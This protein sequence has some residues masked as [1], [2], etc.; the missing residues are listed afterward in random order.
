MMCLSTCVAACYRPVYLSSDN[1][2]CWQ[3]ITTNIH[4]QHVNDCWEEERHRKHISTIMKV[5][6]FD[7]PP[8]VHVAWV[9]YRCACKKRCFIIKYHS[10]KLMNSTILLLSKFC[11]TFRGHQELLLL[12]VNRHR[13]SKRFLNGHQHSFFYVKVY[14]LQRK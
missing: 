5:H 6:P 4:R 9:A 14:S 2:C 1:I 8:C 12:T 13:D 7:K 10:L 11:V 3:T